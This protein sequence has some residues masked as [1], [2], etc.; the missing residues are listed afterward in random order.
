MDTTATRRHPGTALIRRRA[1]VTEMRRTPH[2]SVAWRVHASVAGVTSCKRH[3]LSVQWF[4]R[5]LKFVC[6]REW[7]TFTMDPLVFLQR[8]PFADTRLGDNRNT[9]PSTPTAP[10]IIREPVHT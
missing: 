3:S 9:Y 4:D 10:V 6:C 7:D 5:L 1:L 8:L 2:Q